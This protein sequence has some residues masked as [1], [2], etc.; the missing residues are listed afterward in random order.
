MRIFLSALFLGSFLLPTY[1]QNKVWTDS[2]DHLIE[3][4]SLF[5]ANEY[6]KAIAEFQEISSNDTN[7]ILAQLEQALCYTELKN[8]SMV[9]KI[10]RSALPV[11]NK[12]DH[13]F[14]QYLIESLVHLKNDEAYEQIA[15]AKRKYPF[16]EDFILEEVVANNA[17]EK[18]DQSI[19][20]LQ[21]LIQQNPFNRNAHYYL[22]KI[23]AD[24]GDYVRATISLE[25]FLMMSSVN[26]AKTAA[27]LQILSNI[28]SNKQEVTIK[29]AKKDKLFKDAEEL[30][31]SKLALKAAYKTDAPL[32]DPIVRQTDVLIKNLEFKKG[33][34]DFW[35][36]FYVP[37]LIKVK[38]KGMLRGFTYQFLSFLDYKV[39]Q[40]GVKKFKPEVDKFL[41]FASEYFDE[42]LNKAPVTV[43]GK[44]VV[45]DK[46]YE[47]DC[48]VSMGK[49]DGEKY[50]GTWYFF[51]PEGALQQILHYTDAGVK[52]DTVFDYYIDGRVKDWFIYK[53]GVVEGRNMEY[54]PTGVLK[55]D[56]LFV[57]DSLEGPQ[58]IY[59][60]NG[61]PKEIMDFKKGQR[62]GPATEYTNTG[63]IDMEL[64]YKEGS[65]DGLQKVYFPGKILKT[66][67]Y[68][69]DGERDGLFISYHKNGKLFS[70][71][72]YKAGT[73]VGKWEEFFSN[74]KPQRVYTL[75]EK[76]DYIDSLM[77]YH[78]NG[79]L[80][81][82]THYNAK[83]L[84][85]GLDINYSPSGKLMSIF[86][87]KKDAIKSWKYFSANGKELAAGTKTLTNY[88]EY[89][90]IDS[91]GPIKK[92]FRVGR[93]EFYYPNGEISAIGMYNDLGELEGTYEE[94]YKGGVIKSKTT[95]QKD[96]FTGPYIAYFPN[97][98]VETEGWY[99][100]GQ[101]VGEWTWYYI[102]GKPKQRNYY[103]DD[104]V[105]GIIENWNPDSTLDYTRKY[106]EH[107]FQ[108]ITYYD[109]NNKERIK[110]ET[111]HGNGTFNY[112]SENALMDVHRTYKYGV[113]DGKVTTT[114]KKGTVIHDEN[115]VHGN[116][117]GKQVYRYANGQ[118]LR[119]VEYIHDDEHGTW[120]YYFEDGTISLLRHYSYGQLSDSSVWY[121]PSGTPRVKEY[122]NDMGQVTGIL[123]WYFDNGKVKKKSNYAFGERDGWTY[124]YDPEGRLIYSRWFENGNVVFAKGLAANGK[125]TLTF[126][127]YERSMDVT[128]YYD[129]GKVALS[130]HYENGMLQ[131]PWHKYFYNGNVMEE[132]VMFQDESNGESTDYYSNG[133]I[134][135]KENSYMG[136]LQG[137]QLYYYD[138]GQ[139][140]EEES[141]C[142]G[143]NV[144]EHKVYN[145][146][147]V[148]IVHEEFR[149]GMVIKNYIK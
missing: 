145:K 54:Y 74:G 65:Y 138:N 18:Y 97:G 86:I 10:C 29:N 89:G 88:N 20:V 143:I 96:Q 123:T 38:E 139:L 147:G 12:W 4:V 14:R 45:L 13:L 79:Q 130:A 16:N 85:E 121:Y 91:K 126:N 44:T 146:M 52:T 111:K 95:Y 43:Q 119:E 8:D 33:S 21:K 101:H 84:K 83:G 72:N 51:Y 104:E 1:A 57:A 22:G 110:L 81:T 103:I 9:V 36:D 56:L 136:Q 58:K 94:Y 115:Y 109:A 99:V 59:F 129:N 24:Q 148:L 50:V 76:G 27:A 125:D 116:L 102:N 134:M 117:H 35:M 114:T 78:H 48:L 11:D 2:R 113:I 53:N 26:N 70:K 49:R 106:D 128:V 73:P 71:G 67:V 15:M 77:T 31:E 5:T 82:V 75:N 61:A 40:D 55:S 122:Y 17:W 41:T 63:E 124:D 135:D 87:Y 92:G 3:G 32:D 19:A 112:E 131:G 47:D 64:N 132:D 39:V 142:I 90:N 6:E 93:W 149:Q 23:K 118:V 46:G 98:K 62:H 28:F 68:Y 80:A 133:K 100:N 60:A 108:S 69:K 34:N 127:T 140:R 42:I 144:G 66:D 137:L 141:D 37:F 7:Y 107:L 120:K 30:M 25:T 105:N